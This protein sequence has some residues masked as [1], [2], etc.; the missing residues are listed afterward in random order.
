MYLTYSNIQISDESLLA[1]DTVDKKPHLY[2]LSIP[3]W[4]YGFF[5]INTAYENR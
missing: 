5:I 3:F 4:D 2:S 1:Y